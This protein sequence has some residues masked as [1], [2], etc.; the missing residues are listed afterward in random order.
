M[1]EQFEKLIDY[2]D[3]LQNRV[4]VAF[5][6]NRLLKLLS[7]IY[8][9]QKCSVFDVHTNRFQPNF[10]CERLAISMI[11]TT[12]PLRLVFCRKCQSLR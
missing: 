4:S 8:P 1:I 6:K 11:I 3:L 12:C 5:R 9:K 7:Q 2:P 10:C